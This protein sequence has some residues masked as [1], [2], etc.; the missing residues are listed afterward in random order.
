M[1]NDGFFK[2]ERVDVSEE[3][4]KEFK[5][6]VSF[7]DSRELK[8]WFNFER[9]PRSYDWRC[10]MYTMATKAENRL[11]KLY[12]LKS[13][14]AKY[15]NSPSSSLEAANAIFDSMK[16]PGII[17]A[18]CKN[19]TEKFSYYMSYVIYYNVS[20]NKGRIDP[21]NDLSQRLTG[22]FNKEQIMAY[23][24]VFLSHEK[25]KLLT[26]KE[27]LYKI[28]GACDGILDDLNIFQLMIALAPDE[29]W[30]CVINTL[31]K[32]DLLNLLITPHVLSLSLI[33]RSHLLLNSKLSLIPY[34]IMHKHSVK[35][36]S[37]YEGSSEQKSLHNY[38]NDQTKAN[39]Q[40]L[41]IQK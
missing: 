17:E 15:S 26:S 22:P 4:T 34:S 2:G 7:L 39:G 23:L 18:E 33:Q 11:Q 29:M 10:L 19:N 3:V 21:L 38:S 12:V 36:L 16:F 27:S 9:D 8:V 30:E 40:E 28:K 35:I 1:K 24:K 37:G 5:A 31:S 20:E 6:F 13:S 25:D 32:D 41:G 14:D